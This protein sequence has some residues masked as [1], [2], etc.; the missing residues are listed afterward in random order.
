MPLPMIGTWNVIV[1]G[2]RPFAIHGD[3]YFEVHVTHVDD[4]T[5]HLVRVPAHAISQSLEPGSRVTLTFLMGQVTE[6]RAG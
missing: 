2:A 6:V 4:R 5:D 1:N 3:S